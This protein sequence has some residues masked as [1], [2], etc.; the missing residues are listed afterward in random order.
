MP[1]RF[2]RGITT[3]QKHIQ[4]TVVIDVGSRNA[5]VRPV[6]NPYRA[7]PNEREVSG[8]VIPQHHDVTVPVSRDQVNI[9]IAVEVGISHTLPRGGANRRPA[10]DRRKPHL[11]FVAIQFVAFTRRISGL[12][13]L[14]AELKRGACAPADLRGASPQPPNAGS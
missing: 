11:P 3:D 9:S 6:P 10:L 5:A 12:Q 13:D 7:R 1:N 8:T 2:A 4:V 14:I